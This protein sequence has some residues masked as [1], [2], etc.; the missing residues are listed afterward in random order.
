MCMVSGKKEII[1]TKRVLKKPKKSR[2]KRIIF[3]FLLDLLVTITVLYLFFYRPSFYKP[4]VLDPG[5][6][7]SGQVST[8]L[9]HEFYPHI[10]NNIQYERPFDVIVTQDGLNDIINQADW[11]MESEGV[12]LH[13]PAAVIV[14]DTIVL[15]GAANL[16]GAEFI[17]TIELMPK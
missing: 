13:S 10:Y 5:S 1:T 16:K 8:Y 11:P 6:S 9:T 7:E 15:M 17:I 14:P 2:L 4:I 3:W 12:I